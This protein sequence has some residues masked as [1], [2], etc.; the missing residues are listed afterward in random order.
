V[1]GLH[2]TD[3]TAGCV[4]W[5]VVKPR[6]KFLEFPLRLAVNMAEPLAFTAAGALAVKPALP[7]PDPIV[8]ES[9]TLTAAL[10]LLSETLV[11]LVA[12]AL[13]LTVHEAV[14]GGVRL[15]GAQDRLES[16]GG[17]PGALKVSV[18]FT[19][20]L[21]RLAVSRA[22]LFT[23]TTDGAFAVNPALLEPAETVTDEGTLTDPLPLASPTLIGLAVVALKYT[24]QEVVAGGV[25]LD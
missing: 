8:T 12:A 11:A 16:T 9:G 1:L 4:T 20:T 21:F 18:K 19:E 25:R 22:E 13:R 17:P 5:A 6:E 24:V 2:T 7:A 14:P 15:A 23:L 3:E 10:P